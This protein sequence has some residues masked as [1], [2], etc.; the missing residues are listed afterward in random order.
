MLIRMLDGPSICSQKNARPCELN[1]H[2]F[3]DLRVDRRVVFQ[4]DVRHVR[5]ERSPNAETLEFQR[6]RP[7]V[8]R[9]PADGCSEASRHPVEPVPG[10]NYPATVT[11]IVTSAGPSPRQ[12]ISLIVLPSF[13][14][15]N[16]QVVMCRVAFPGNSTVS[17]TLPLLGSTKSPNNLSR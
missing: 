17:S 15:F 3:Y 4:C 8:A 5:N 6:I 1:G 12:D 7:S 11:L 14:T 16:S 2:Y 10:H 13:S 9:I